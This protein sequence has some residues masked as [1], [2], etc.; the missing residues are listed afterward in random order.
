MHRTPE[1]ELMDT[2]EQAQSYAAAD[3]VET[4][5]RFAQMCLEAFAGSEVRHVADLGC[6]PGNIALQIAALDT[7]LQIVGYDGAEA[8]LAHGRE[9]SVASGLGERVRFERSFIPNPELPAQ[10]FDAVIS[11]SLLHHL[12]DPQGLWETIKHIARPGAPVCIGDLRRPSTP[13]EADRLTALY[14]SD[15]PEILRLDF[16][17]SLH[18]AFE[19]TEIEGQLEAAGISGWSVT[20]VGDRHVYIMGRMP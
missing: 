4:D 2:A 17:A 16:H 11:N 9:Q 18:A 12:H 10:A 14:A 13:Q 15:V 8:M 3:F 19:V 5:V 20:A 6:G 1:P 7:D